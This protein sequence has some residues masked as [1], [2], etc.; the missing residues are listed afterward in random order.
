MADTRAAD[1]NAG[2][3]AQVG[4]DR[5]IEIDAALVLAVGLRGEPHFGHRHLAGIES[6]ILAEQMEQALREQAGDEQQRGA[7]RN[8]KADQPSA[9]WLP[10]RLP[11]VRPL[12]C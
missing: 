5:V 10:C 4:E 6:F 11:S 7:A 2:N 1:S 12:D 3:G 9:K 8:L